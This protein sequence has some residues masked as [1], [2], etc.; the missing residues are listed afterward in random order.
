MHV[1]GVPATRP[2]PAK[3]NACMVC[4]PYLIVC[5]VPPTPVMSAT[6]NVT[7]PFGFCV[8]A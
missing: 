8:T 5:T 3:L 7:V 2:L 6:D 4:D 1:G